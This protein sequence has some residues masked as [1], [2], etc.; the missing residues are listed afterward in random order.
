MIQTINF[1][2]CLFSLCSHLLYFYFCYFNHCL[3]SVAALLCCCNAF[4]MHLVHS[5]LMMNNVHTPY[6]VLV[7]CFKYLCDWSSTSFLGSSP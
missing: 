7:V 1:L 3:I 5:M 2:H 6:A 4:C